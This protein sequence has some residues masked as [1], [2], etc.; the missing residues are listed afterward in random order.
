MVTLAWI[1][2]AT[3]LL[4]QAVRR[5]VNA[6]DGWTEF[7]ATRM[8]WDDREKLLRVAEENMTA[9]VTEAER[10]GAEW[11]VIWAAGAGVPATA[12]P[13]LDDELH[14]FV[15]IF[16]AIASAAAAATSRGS[17]FITS[18]AGGVY[19]GSAHPPFTE[20]TE[21]LPVTAYGWFKLDVEAATARFAA[22]T[23]IP[24]LIGRITNLYGPGQRLG[25]VQGLISHLA[26]SSFTNDPI[27]IFAPLETIREYVF[28]DDC[29]DLILRSME[30]L[31]REHGESGGVVM[32]ILG[33]GQSL[34]ISEL[35]GYLHGISKRPPRVI[36]GVTSEGAR[37]SVDLR[38]TSIV[39]PELDDME[40]MPIAAGFHATMLE[41][42]GRV[43]H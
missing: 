38:M 31:R 30:R 2:G 27:R 37:Q 18:S 28:V 42:L 7:D 12:K 24:V 8:P 32:K 36:L 43:T 20:E 23:G 33:V 13:A 10:S 34:S 21:P 6:R 29:A 3:G 22:E 9:L 15:A 4:G 25:K 41:V 14:D 40:R 16:A 19:G 26:L 5:A 35:L 1:I 17:V 39:W 11:C